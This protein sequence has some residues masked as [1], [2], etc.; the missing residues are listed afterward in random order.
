QMNSAFRRRWWQ[1]V[2]G[3]KATRRPSVGRPRRALRLEVLEDRSLPSGTPVMVLDINPGGTSS[4]PSE[5]VAVGPTT[6]FIA[7]DGV[8]GSELW[9]SDGTA[10]GT[11]LVKDINPGSASP[12]LNWSTN[13]NGTLFFAAV[14]GTNGMEL[15]KSDGT[16]AGTVLVKDINPGSG[17]SSPTSLTNV[18]GT[19]FFAADDGTN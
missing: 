4:A 11:V 5:M 18:N 6:Y 9:K 14:D 1:T 16:A 7:D 8:H 2:F 3:P 17:G 10:T 13:V 19:L 15:W 12:N